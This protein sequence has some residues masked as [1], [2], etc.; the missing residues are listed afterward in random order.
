MNIISYNIRGLGRGVKWAAIRRLIRKQNVDMICLQE[1]KKE[2]IDKVVCQSL[3]GEAEVCWEMQ[4][5]T[6]TAGGILCLWSERTFK[7]HSRVV[8]NG[9]ILLTGEYLKEA[10]TVNIVAVYSPCDIQNKRILWDQIK[11]LKNTQSGDLWCVMGD[12]NSIRD[13]SERFGICQREPKINSIQEFNEWIEDLEVVEAPWTG[14]SFTWFRPNGSSRSKIDR[15][16][17]SPEW[18]DT[19]P[20]SIQSTL[21]R[22]FSDHCPI[23]LRSTTID[24]GPKPFRVLDC[25]LSDPSFKE[26]VK[27][28][29]LSSQL[30]GWGGFVLK[31][32]IKIL[33]Q[34]LKI[35]NKES[36]GDTLKKVIKI[37]EELN[38]LEEETTNRQL[39]VEEVSK[40]KQLQEALWVAA[41]AHESLLRQKARIRWIKLGD[42]NSRYF[43]LMMNANRRNNFVNG[44]I[45]GDSW[46]ADPATVKEEIRSF[47]SQKFQEASNHN[48]RLDG[49][50]F[51]SLSQQHNDMLTARFEEEEVKTAVWECG[52]DKCPGPDGLNFKFIKQ[53]WQLMKPEILR[54]L[55]EFYVNGVI[56]KGCNASFITL[57]PKVADPQILNDYRPIS[58]I[59]CI[60]KIVSKVLANK[61]KRVMHLII[62]E[63]QSAFIE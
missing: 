51:Q 12:F 46:V 8:G 10:Q 31:E 13:S 60:Y 9:Y 48:I 19:W 49:V 6:H 7:L 40:R 50:R 41:H 4:P 1:T 47:F 27:N 62:H 32:K 23:I 5:A 29:W 56:P 53:F 21:S 24:W 63:T 39:S 26:T 30:P 61:M 35:W 3:W 16:L 25:W 18:L 20:A 43:H 42:C 38:K 22:N 55:D 52:S 11:Q 2:V 44:V 57:I 28:C 17:L 59:G 15:F 33:K 34:K 36:Y 37:E 58:L 14:R 45:I 54:F